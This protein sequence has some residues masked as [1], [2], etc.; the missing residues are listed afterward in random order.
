MKRL[1]FS[2]VTGLALVA[3]S[4]VPVFADEAMPSP[5]SAAWC[6]EH[7]TDSG[8][9]APSTPESVSST[10]ASANASANASAETSG[11]ISTPVD[12]SAWFSA[13][14][15]ALL[16]LEEQKTLADKLN[17][18]ASD[19]V[20]FKKKVGQLRE[21]LGERLEEQKDKMEN[22]A[23]WE[24]K[25]KAKFEAKVD[26][27]FARHMREKKDAME[28]ARRMQEKEE[29]L[30]QE[31]IER[32]K[33]MEAKRA[34]MEAARARRAAKPKVLQ[35]WVASVDAV[36]GVI[37]LKKEGSQ[38]KVLVTAKT[39]LA[40]IEDDGARAGTLADFQAG[41]R[42]FGL[43]RRNPNNHSLVGVVL[44]KM[45]ARDVDDDD[46]DENEGAPVTPP[47]DSGTTQP[48]ADSQTTP[49]ATN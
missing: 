45:Q 25:Q 23:Q 32:M 1:A 29:R 8:C 36:N 11:S 26:A 35:A 18:L 10:D 19:P 43:V 7:P 49:P 5:D 39:V 4:A 31:K 16:S 42:I 3:L 46:E 44:V 9:A 6:A 37:V 15:L 33:R 13:E 17:A 38:A 47:L 14:G 41:D 20:A 22:Q 2:L 24:A 28:Q 34:R 30:R 12:L 27:Q 40:V 48:P 21:W